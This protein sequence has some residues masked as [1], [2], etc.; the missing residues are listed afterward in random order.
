MILLPVYWKN[1]QWLLAYAINPGCILKNLMIIKKKSVH[2]KWMSSF[3]MALSVDFFISFQNQSNPN[4]MNVFCKLL[5]LILLDLA[6]N[7]TL[8]NPSA[9]KI[10]KSHL[11]FKNGSIMKGGILWISFLNPITIKHSSC[12]YLGLS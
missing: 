7:E 3:V 4:S 2:G 9:Y 10:I 11:W 1:A 12:F 5:G 6:Y 8:M